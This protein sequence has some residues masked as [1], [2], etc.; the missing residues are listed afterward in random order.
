MSQ[1]TDKLLSTTKLAKQLGIPGRDLF[2]KLSDL[3]WISRDGG[4]LGP[5]I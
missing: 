1:T 4:E 3:G 2:N 5:D